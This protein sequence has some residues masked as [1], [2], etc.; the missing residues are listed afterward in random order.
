MV[1][2]YQNVFAVQ[3]YNKNCIYANFKGFFLK[4]L[5]RRVHFPSPLWGNQTKNLWKIWLFLDVYKLDVN[6]CICGCYDCVISS[7]V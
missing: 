2:I 7:M 3:R 5:Q 6:R 4:N 1:I